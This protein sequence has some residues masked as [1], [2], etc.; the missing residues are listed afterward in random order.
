MSFFLRNTIQ[1]DFIQINSSL[2]VV[3]TVRN[4]TGN[5]ILK[6]TP[7]YLSGHSSNHDLPL[8][9]TANATNENTMPC[10][11]ISQENIENNSNGLIK[12][13]GKL[14]LDTSSYDFNI[15]D[16]LYVSTTGT[17]TNIEPQGVGIVVQSVGIMGFKD[18]NNGFILV[19]IVGTASGDIIEIKAD[20]SNIEND[21]DN[22]LTYIDFT[23][24]NLNIVSD[25][26]IIIESESN[27]KVFFNSDV[28]MSGNL[29]VLGTTLTISSNI[30]VIDD[31]VIELGESSPFE[32]FFDRGIKGNWYDNGNRT[33]FF[34]MSRD[35]EK[36]TFIPNAF[37][38]NAN[39][40]TGSPGPAIFS[41]LELTSTVDST[42]TTTGALIVSGGA[43]IDSNLYVGND[44]Y[45]EGNL[46]IDNNN[47]LE[48]ITILE[49]SNSA[50]N[51]RVDTL[52]LS[53]SAINSRVDTLELSNSA[54]NSRVDTLELSNSAINSRVDILELSNS[55]INSRVDILELSNSAINSRVDSFESNISNI[56]L[57]NSNLNI[58]SYGNINLNPTNGNV[59]VNGELLSAISGSG[60]GS[61][62]TSDLDL[63]NIFIRS[64]ETIDQITKLTASDGSSGDIFG[65]SV[66][67][68]GN[69]IVI[70]AYGDDDNGSLS[71]S[72]YVFKNDGNG[73][74]TQID[75]LIASDGTTDDQFGWSVS[76]YG[77][78]IV[79]GSNGD[80]DNGSIS[81]SAYVFK[82]D[83]NDSFDQIDKLTASDGSS[84]DFFGGSVSIYGDYIVIGSIG[85]DD[86]GSASGS[87]YVFKNDG[88]DSFDQ[89]DKL[90]ANDGI[91]GDQFGI[92]VSMYGDYI[93]IGA[94]G[95]DD[96][97]SGS[98]SA[99]VFKNDGN[100][101]FDQIDKL[102]A[103]DGISGDQFGISVAIYSN[104]IV[105]GAN[106]DDDNG[107]SS[108]SAYVFKNDGNDS[109]DQID[110]L[111]A[112][113]GSSGDFFGIAVNIYGDYIVI[114][115][116]GDDIN[117]NDS[118]S[119]YVFK[120]D[121]ND[122]FDQIAKLTDNDGA[123]FDELGISVAINGDYIVI[124]AIRDDDNGTDSGSA[125]VYKLNPGTL[126]ISNVSINLNSNTQIQ[127][128]DE[129][130]YIKYNNSNIDIT[131]DT[132]NINLNPTNGN[133]YVNGVLLSAISNNGNG[134][135]NGSIEGI[136]YSDPHLILES[137]TSGNIVINAESNVNLGT[138]TIISN[139]LTL[140]QNQ[141]SLSG[142]QSITLDFNDSS[143]FYFTVAT[144]A[145]ITLNNPTN[146]SRVGQQGSLVFKTSGTG[147]ILNW[148][149]GG[150][151]Y[152][153]SGLAPSFTGSNATIDIFSYMIV[154]DDIVIVNDAVNFT[155]Y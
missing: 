32:T 24:S 31:P 120:N 62:N 133:V 49:D 139:T 35:S 121:G 80:D 53:N 151:W 131:L 10:I 126:Q 150:K 148:Y 109:F 113:D 91:S 79:I 135:G 37:F 141:S 41:K 72:V 152:F 128:N 11:G 15:G 4:E 2:K 54:I 136:T 55:A 14:S 145:N 84:V 17:L 68:Y 97:G 125:Y 88:N 140:T 86:N 102:T 142:T 39:I 146:T 107:Y 56:V 115:A 130:K 40:A 92:S 25:S 118:G 1:E 114:G 70:G 38:N 13:L 112:N 50:I 71:G 20:I 5:T 155:Q 83:G 104:Y 138:H 103:N 81:G 8:I 7:V 98:G 117:F 22:I 21:I 60:S 57:T 34:G 89:I 19:K 33:L 101:S 144:G 36:F 82:N 29:Q 45:V 12:Q 149:S 105:I 106:G 75:K 76:M 93:V 16:K 111:T 73:N 48:K 65:N 43:G 77:D 59:F 44:I 127:F 108:G 95:D 58:S 90:T 63:S 99:Y 6:G 74:I 129:N 27:G 124:C 3:L 52:E 137:G 119:A 134:S 64:D 61:G 26:N 28:Q 69:Y 78:Y 23:D 42:S 123:F 153:N 87:A 143:D 85:D 154:E 100:D 47:I 110:K 51:S 122:S 18:A 30:T 66:A 116:N 96:N 132:G 147:H 67:M 46:F 9:S 94:Y